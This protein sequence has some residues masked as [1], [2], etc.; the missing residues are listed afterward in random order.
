MQCLRAAASPPFSV[1][2][3]GL[4]PEPSILGRPGCSLGSS[5]EVSHMQEFP[6]N[7]RGI[8]G[9]LL[10]KK[11]RCVVR[12]SYIFQIPGT[13]RAGSEAVMSVWRREWAVWLLLTWHQVDFFWRLELKRSETPPC[14]PGSFTRL[15]SFNSEQ[16][17]PSTCARAGLPTYGSLY[18]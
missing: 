1:P 14:R 2:G 4:S 3:V 5:F 17:H 18:T 16:E 6:Y 9:W 11:P 8:C 15:D 12:F 13:R 7:F 10:A